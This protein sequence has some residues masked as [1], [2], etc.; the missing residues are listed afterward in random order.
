[1]FFWRLSAILD[2]KVNDYVR[3][4]VWQT[5]FW[6]CG[7]LLLLGLGFLRDHDKVIGSW[8]KPPRKP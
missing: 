1:C 5:I 4:E 2:V 3:S 6:I 8:R 7:P